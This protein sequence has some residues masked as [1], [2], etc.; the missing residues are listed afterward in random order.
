MMRKD[1]FL[2][3]LDGTL[4]D[5]MLGI[6]KSVQ[7]ALRHYGIIVE[8]LSLLTPFIGPPLVDSFM[9]FYSFS[10]ERA[11]EAVS[12]YR[13]YF[14]ETGI[15]ENEEIL[16]IR[17]MLERLQGE[18]K[19]LF[20]ATSKPEVF[21]RRVVEFFA[22][23][24]Y[25]VF[26]GGADMDE[27]RVKKGDVIR[28]VLEEAGVEGDEDK[29]RVVMIG[30]REHDILGAKENGIR[31]V[32]VLFGYG[33]REELEMAGADRIAEDV[34]GLQEILLGEWDG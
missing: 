18:G 3:D 27:T 9:R 30:D 7:Y 20:V 11:R 24:K 12:V 8:D 19:R 2:F 33:S 4:T 14:A 31:S 32:G 6:T 22:L 23:E 10:R 29:Q 25:F 15:F 26:V 13:E 34:E 17:G 16:G 5:P 1:I 21:A 28:Y